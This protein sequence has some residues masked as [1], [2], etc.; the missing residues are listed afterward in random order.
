MIVAVF[1]SVT[2]GNQSLLTIDVDMQVCCTVSKVTAY[3]VNFTCSR[4]HGA[5]N[6]RGER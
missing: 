2:A 3:R 5:V 6:C 4:S 1:S